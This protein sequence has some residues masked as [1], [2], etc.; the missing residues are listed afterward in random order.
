MFDEDW[1][2][3]VVLFVIIIVF[4]FFFFFRGVFVGPATAV[5]ALET[6]GYSDV[7]I[8]DKDVFLVQVRGCSN[9]DAAKFE[10]AAKNPLSKEVKVNVCI[11]WPFKA[12]T[13]RTD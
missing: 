5:R 12:A 10:A 9:S 3:G 4:I 1:K 13:V 11:G 2:N 7:K 6:Q 8:L